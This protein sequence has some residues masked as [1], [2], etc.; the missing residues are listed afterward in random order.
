MG[1]QW[2]KVGYAGEDTPRAVLPTDLGVLEDASVDAPAAA[3]AMAVD[4]AEGGSAVA[5]AN[6]A[7]RKTYIGTSTLSIRRDGMEIVNPIRNGLGTPGDGP[8]GEAGRTGGV[9]TRD[10]V[11]ARPAV[12]PWP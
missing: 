7:A 12:P 11:D 5:R 1:T 3:E 2:T 9:L 4:G 10:A 6:R 8:A